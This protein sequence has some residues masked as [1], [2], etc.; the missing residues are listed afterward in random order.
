[1]AP[2]PTKFGAALS[3]DGGN[4]QLNLRGYPDPGSGHFAFTDDQL[5][6][7]RE[8]DEDGVWD[9][10]LVK[11]P[12]SEII[13]LRD[14]LNKWLPPAEGRPSDLAAQP[15]T[16]APATDESQTLREIRGEA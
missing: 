16:S 11:L 9:G 7:V 13:A 15:T 12:A 5:E 10:F 14:F 2:Y 4:L 8:Y 3:F 1:M 6:P